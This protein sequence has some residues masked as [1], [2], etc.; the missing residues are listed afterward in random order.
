MDGVVK[1]CL[2][3][4][5]V[6][7]KNVLGRAALVWAV[8]PGSVLIHSFFLSFVRWFVVACGVMVCGGCVFSSLLFL[9]FVPSVFSLSN[10]LLFVLSRGVVFF[11]A[12]AGFGGL[13]DLDQFRL[14]HCF[15]VLCACVDDTI[16][17]L[18]T[19]HLRS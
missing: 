19:P 5:A 17:K 6:Q 3:L 8:P 14:A 1:V 2:S 10:L 12:L 4:W 18:V 13:T 15:D 11:C 16:R 7:R 9:F